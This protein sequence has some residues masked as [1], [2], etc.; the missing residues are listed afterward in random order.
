MRYCCLVLAALLL[1]APAA[2][3]AQAGAGDFPSRPIRLVVPYAPGGAT[4]IVARVLA[5]KLSERLGQQI[6]V[7]NR[8]GAA[9]N[10]AVEPLALSSSP[11]DFNAYVQSEMKRWEKI[12][13]ENKVAID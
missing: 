10:I 11:A 1:S 4:D 9:G 8:A 2:A 12:I 6:V 3:Y 7:D 13:G 5:P